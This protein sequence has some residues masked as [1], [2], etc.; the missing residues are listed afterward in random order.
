MAPDASAPLSARHFHPLCIRHLVQTQVLG[1][2]QVA[3]QVRSP[4]RRL[5]E[6]PTVEGLAMAIARRL[7]ERAEPGQIATVLA[8]LETLAEDGTPRFPTGAG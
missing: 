7:A 5:F 1:R 3:F 8:E 2:V 6:V 4:L